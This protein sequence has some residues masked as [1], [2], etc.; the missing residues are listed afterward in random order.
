MLRTNQAE[1]R[2]HSS[3]IPVDTRGDQTAATGHTVR[4]PPCEGIDTIE[5]GL[6]AARH[7]R[8]RLEERALQ[9]STWHA[10]T[11]KASRMTWKA[12]KK[13][14]PSWKD[15][16]TKRSRQSMAAV[17]HS[18][19]DRNDAVGREGFGGGRCQQSVGRSTSLQVGS[20]QSDQVDRSRLPATPAALTDATKASGRRGA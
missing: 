7:V 17:P 6:A 9:R 1:T 18:G 5:W 13:G 15:T 11:T 4:D 8:V 14:G 16:A 19:R 3:G 10:G 20:F 12:E 2:Q